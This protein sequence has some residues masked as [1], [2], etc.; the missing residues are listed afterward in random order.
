MTDSVVGIEGSGRHRKILCPY[1]G[2]GHSS[3]RY[4]SLYVELSANAWAARGTLRFSVSQAPERHHMN[5]SRRQ[6]LR[7]VT[8]AAALPVMPHFA[9]AQ[10]YPTRPVRIIVGFPPAGANDLYA[11]LIAQWLSERL[12]QQ[13]IVDNR[14][15]AGGNIGTEAAAKASPDGYTLLLAS[16]VDT[17]NSTLYPNLRFNFIRDIEP[18]ATISRGMGV[19]VV[20]PAL[21]VKSVPELLVY[22]KNNPGKI[23]VATS[24]IGSA[25]HMYWELFRSVTGVNMLHVPYRGGGPAL[26][27]LLGG[28]VQAYFA[29]MASAI[30]HV[31]A[32]KLRA[33]AVTGAIRADVLPDIPTLAEFIPGYAAS[34][35]WGIGAPANTPAEILGKLNKEINAGLTDPKLKARIAE[36]GD[37][38]FASSTSDFVKL[39]TE[40]TEKWGKVIRFTGIKPE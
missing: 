5:L 22:A 18:V 7:L 38:A 34:S 1:L 31:R 11:R 14:P 35:W 3:D 26:T 21:P 25:P 12:D 20:N 37:T 17:W 39:I 32:G 33:L 23:T 13:F 6:F 28:Q 29:T 4:S 2:L 27:D 36:L 24:G 19:L 15:G 40:D 8:G 16:S 9:W 30:E 10:A